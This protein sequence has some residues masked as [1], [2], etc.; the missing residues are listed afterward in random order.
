MHIGFI[1]DGNGRW[2]T[3]KGLSRLEGHS[4]G[5]DVGEQMMAICIREKIEYATF[6]ALSLQNWSRPAQEL[7]HII[8]LIKQFITKIRP[9]LLANNAKFLCIGNQQHLPADL[10]DLLNRLTQ[11]TKEA[12]GTVISLCVSYGGREEILDLMKSI[13]SLSTMTTKSISALLPLPDIDLVIRTSGEYRIS[14][15]MLWQSAYA[16]YYFTNTLWPDFTEAELLKAIAEFKGRDRRFGTVKVEEEEPIESIEDTY[17]LL[18]ELFAEY[19]DIVDVR[20]LYNELVQNGVP[21]PEEGHNKTSDSAY[22]SAA[23]AI[24]FL[25]DEAIDN[26]PEQCTALKQLSTDFSIETLEHICGKQASIVQHFM[27]MSFREK[28]LYKQIYACKHLQRITTDLYKKSIY[29]FI[30]NY[31]YF[32]MIIGS[33]VT[34][35]KILLISI[36]ASF[37][38]NSLD[39]EDT[40]RIISNVIKDL[41]DEPNRSLFINRTIMIGVCALLHKLD[42]SNTYPVLNSLEQCLKYIID[43]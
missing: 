21:I 28:E 34:V 41:W 37:V 13:P 8:Q 32:T 2:A 30:S 42:P 10:Q 18:T 29:R 9:T 35:N 17:E 11:D 12:T 20:P 19:N 43:G 3:A 27:T 5:A 36:I 26:L 39:T 38:D 15:F 31:N 23:I 14:N 4:Q 6:Y 25:V 40:Y 16:E 22:S 24:G 1:M 33:F 7:R